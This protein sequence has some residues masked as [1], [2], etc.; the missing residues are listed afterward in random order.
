MEDL[1]S[2]VTNLTGAVNAI[3]EKMNSLERRVVRLDTISAAVTMSPGAR[4]G[5]TA[6]T[7]E[8]P[9]QAPANEADLKDISHLPDCVKELRVFDG[10]PVEYVSWIHSVETI[11]SDFKVVQGKPLYRAILQHVRQ[12][13]RGAADAALV[14]YN[15]FDNSW[16]KIKECLSLHYADKR[17]IRTL[18]HQLHQLQ[19]KGSKIDEFYAAVNHQFSLIINKIKTES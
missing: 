4:S 19:Q 12:K 17:D 14:S 15:I 7:E 16:S 18:E 9:F 8:V 3:L 1:R 5:D 6:N 10:N 11:L 13:V 2:T